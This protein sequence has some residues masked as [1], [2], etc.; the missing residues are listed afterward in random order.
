MPDGRYEVLLKP[1]V[2]VSAPMLA[3]LNHLMSTDSEQDSGEG[4]P[5]AGT[6]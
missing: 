2:T 3:V 4:R 1:G 6:G 5:I